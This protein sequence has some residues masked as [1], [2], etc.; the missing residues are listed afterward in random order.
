M[1]KCHDIEKKEEET[2]FLGTKK[3]I[4][5]YGTML[6]T[7]RGFLCNYFNILLDFQA[8]KEDQK[9]HVPM[10]STKVS[11]SCEGISV[12]KRPFFTCTDHP[13]G[14]ERRAQSHEPIQRNRSSHPQRES[15]GNQREKVLND[16]GKF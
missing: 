6:N 16:L 2:G 3:M 11:K 8:L 1:K 13:W 5:A 12:T 7:R 4:P 15:A 9:K 14:T 10:G